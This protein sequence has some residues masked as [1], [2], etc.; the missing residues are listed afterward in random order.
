ME[1][2][3]SGQIENQH[4]AYLFKKSCNEC[5]EGTTLSGYV[6]AIESSV[7]VGPCRYQISTCSENEGQ[8]GLHCRV[9]LGKETRLNSL[10][11]SLK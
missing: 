3:L 1:D 6:D 10:C 2:Y 9:I 11:T 4:L 7:F 8:S 5:G